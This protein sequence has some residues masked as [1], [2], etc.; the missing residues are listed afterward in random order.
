[1]KTAIKIISTLFLLTACTKEIPESAKKMTS[2]TGDYLGQ[3]PPG[4]TADV[5]GLGVVSTG[6]NERD[7]AFTP[8]GREFYYSIWQYS[9]GTIV[10]MKRIDNGW[11]Q[12]HVVSFSGKFNDIEPFITSDGNKLYFASNRPLEG[13]EPKDFDIWYVEKN[14]EGEWGDPVVLGSAI[15]TENDEFYPSLT[16]EGDLYFTARNDK[17]F[18]RED[19]FVSKFVDG[20]YQEYE[21]LGDSVNSPKDEFNSFIA[22]DGSYLVYTT[23]GFGDGFGGGDLWVTFKKEDGGW[24]RP[25]NLGD[26]VNSNKLEYCPSITLDGKYLFFTSNRVNDRKYDKA[27]SYEQLV[28]EYNNPYNGAGDIYWV[29]TEV[30]DKLKE[31]R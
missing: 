5:F 23:T 25:E 12:P 22:K 1:M 28:K 24:T 14:E 4:Q 15:N 27:I 18:G 16:D 6:M 30:I 17:A 11:T 10:R 3:T 26:G 8:D 7:A 2:L 13:D 29:S 9:R 19:I 21:N 20:V 31:K